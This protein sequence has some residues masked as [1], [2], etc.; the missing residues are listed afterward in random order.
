MVLFL[1]HK[2]AR[3]D[4]VEVGENIRFLRKLSLRFN[5]TRADNEKMFRILP[6]T[7]SLLLNI[8]AWL[9]QAAALFLILIGLGLQP[10]LSL[11]ALS[12]LVLAFSIMIGFLS[13]MPGG[14]GVVELALAGLLSVLM[15]FQPELAVTATILFRLSTFWISLLLG[16]LFWPNA[17]R[18]HRTTASSP[19]GDGPKPMGSS[20]RGTRIWSGSAR[21][22]RNRRYGPRWAP[23]KMWTGAASWRR[24][25]PPA[26]A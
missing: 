21:L 2:P 6:L 10:E 9:T 12:C 19:F 5:A 22:F 25:S 18:S 16:I 7:F 4:G 24:C 17:A 14:L 23:G 26:G 20:G 15:G 13:T 3:D 8:L 1:Q 11:A